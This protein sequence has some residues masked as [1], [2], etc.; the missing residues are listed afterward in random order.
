I[1]GVI[2]APIAAFLANKIPTRITML[3]VGIVVIIVSLKR[4]FL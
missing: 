4:L 2:A 3:L 1:G